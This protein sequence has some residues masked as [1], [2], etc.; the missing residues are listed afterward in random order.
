MTTTWTT[1]LVPNVTYGVGN[2]TRCG[3]GFYMTYIGTSLA[4]APT[5]KVLPDFELA[6]WTHFLVFSA[7]SFSEASIPASHL[8]YDMFASVSDV[9]YDG[10]D[11]DAEELGGNISWLP[12]NL[13]ER[14]H[15]YRVYLAESID[16]LSRWWIP[17]EVEVGSN[18]LLLPADTLRG[19][20]SHILVYTKSELAEQTTPASL[21]FVDTA[22]KAANVSFVDEDL[23]HG[24][25]GGK[26]QWDPP[27][28]LGPITDYWIYL[29]AD[30]MGN[31]R[32]YLGSTTVGVNE[33]LV[34]ADTPLLTGMDSY[35]LVFA[36]SLLQEQTTPVGTL[37]FDRVAS[38]SQVAFEDHDLDLEEIGGNVTWSEPVDLEQLEAYRLYLSGFGSSSLITEVSKGT[39]EALLE[40][41][42]A[43][44]DYTELQIYTKSQLAEQ[45]TPVSFSLSDTSF[46][47]I[48][49]TFTDLDLD[50]T[51]LGGPFSWV[52]AK[53]DAQV[54]FYNIYLGFDCTENITL[55]NVGNNELLAVISGR[56]EFTFGGTVEELTTAL[57]TTLAQQLQVDISAVY[58]QVVSASSSRRLSTAW[59]VQY[60][61]VLPSEQAN[62]VMSTLTDV[63]SDSTSFRSV[64]ATELLLAGASADVVQAMVIAAITVP[65]LQYV[66][67]EQLPALLPDGTNVTVVPAAKTQS[68]STED[69]DAVPS[70]DADVPSDDSEANGTAM[71]SMLNRRLSNTDGK[72]LSEELYIIQLVNGSR[73]R[74]VSCESRRFLGQVPKRHT[75]YDVPV[76]TQFDGNATHLLIYATSAYAEASIASGFVRVDDA[77]ANVLNLSFVDEDLDVN[78]LGG[79]VTWGLLDGTLGGTRVEN[80]SVYLSTDDFQGRSLLGSGIVNNSLDLP[81]D[82][83]K[84]T[85]PRL[86][87][88]TLSSLVEQST[89][90]SLVLSD[91]DASV[92]Q[93][94]LDDYDLD[95]LELGGLLTWEEPEDLTQVINYAIY[96]AMGLSNESNTWQCKTMNTSAQIGDDSDGG[97]ILRPCRGALYAEVP[98]GESN[99][100]VPVETHRGNYSHFMIYTRSSFVEQSWPTVLAIY[101]LNASVSNIHFDGKDLDLYDLGGVLSWDPPDEVLRVDVYVAYLATSDVGQNRSLLGNVPVGTNELLIPVETP[102]GIFSNFVIYTKS[103]LVEQTTPSSLLIQDAAAST[104]NLTFGDKDLDQFQ[105]AGNITWTEAADVSDVV[106]Y[107]IY[108]AHDRFGSN[109]SLLGTAPAGS[110]N[111]FVEDN[112]PLLSFTHFVIYSR[113]S[114]VEQTTPSAVVIID[115][116]AAVEDL[117][118]LDLDLDAAE[119]AGDVTWSPPT[120]GLEQV[121]GYG[122]YLSDAAYRTR[123]QVGIVPKGTHVQVVPDSTAQQSFTHVLVYSRSD[124]FQQ[125]TPAATAISDVSAQAVALEF[126][127]LDLDEYQVGGTLQWQE[128]AD[129]RYVAYYTAYKAYF[130]NNSNSS[131]VPWR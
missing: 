22:E 104:S 4:G 5:F 66:A 106:E 79:S 87:V 115:V 8:I 64:L 19:N 43:L 7:S 51:D 10:L 73:Y 128:P 88:Y 3:N 59:I 52:E 48:Q 71:A 118:F 34:P 42:T 95:A 75:R 117:S 102:R 80:I 123:S 37:V 9:R 32:S 103:I 85:Y 63:Q 124:A 69:S 77:E 99:L 60:M 20:F 78:E 23:D 92:S 112:T 11:L 125:S 105:V 53:D 28:D 109:R 83:P 96:W 29:S 49:E 89:P 12:P 111:F 41:E 50:T 31:N 30:M 55:V 57:K 45:T 108:M 86:A 114:L 25:I 54:T 68:N 61:V 27:E 16:G 33:L 91:A 35:L 72:N 56:M 2:M 14:V 17:P 67:S 131:S 120:S 101:D 129:S 93:V 70:D 130:C 119:L 81:A 15:V 76:E 47:V 84:Q 94:A 62:T 100:T 121:N 21:A 46:Y 39:T 24:H 110:G 65:S 58:L 126:S 127:D 107:M 97:S 1:V 18:R 122:V 90:T 116:S 98:V 13:T 26:L 44:G 38:V 40:T 6:N 82:T 74:F 113:S 36:R